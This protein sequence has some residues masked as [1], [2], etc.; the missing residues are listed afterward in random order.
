MTMIGASGTPTPGR[1]RSWTSTWLRQH[2]V[3]KVANASQLLYQVHGLQ[4][5]IKLSRLS[6]TM[7]SDSSPISNIQSNLKSPRIQSR[8]ALTSSRPLRPEIIINSTLIATALWLVS[9]KRFHPCGPMSSILW[10]ITEF[11]ASMVFK[12]STMILKKRFR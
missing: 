8:M 2:S 5:M 12:N 11:N 4:S 3:Q 1:S 9:C 6:S 10:I 7:A